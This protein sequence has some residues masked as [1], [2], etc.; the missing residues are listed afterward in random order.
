VRLDA[1]TPGQVLAL[2]SIVADKAKDAAKD[3]VIKAH[4]HDSEVEVDPFVLAVHG[5]TLSVGTPTTQA[6][7]SRLLSLPV[8]ALLLHRMGATRES[9]MV[10]LETILTETA[11]KDRDATEAYVAGI[12]PAA[13]SI[14]HEVNAMTQRAANPIVRRPTVKARVDGEVMVKAETAKAREAS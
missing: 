13:W 8:L 9:A 1:L 6:P 4:G 12:C 11:G 10:V 7:T 5:G 2:S 14:V 3:A